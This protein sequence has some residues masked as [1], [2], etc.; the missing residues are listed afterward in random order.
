M[1]PDDEPR[2]AGRL[3]VGL[4]APDRGDDAVGAAVVRAV[5]VLDLP[6]VQVIEHEDP[7]ALIDLWSRCD[8]CVVV[9]AVVSGQAPGTVH[10]L[11]TGRDA[12][13]LPS[14]GWAVT[15]RGGTH[16]FGIASAVE[17]ARAMDRL[18]PRL[19]VVGVEAT[20]FE[21]GAPLTAPVA[22]AVDRAVA[23][24]LTALRGEGTD[25]P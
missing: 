20:G 19:V 1:S 18:P 4:G 9:D 25:A 10:V 15:G 16:A 8:L 22:H 14:S 13:P 3:V 24:V 11:E 6:G 21:H 7:T 2:L 17:L 12:E 23:V 5:A